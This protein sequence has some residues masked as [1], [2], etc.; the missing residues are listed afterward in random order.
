MKEVVSVFPNRKNYMLT[1]RSWDFI[2]F[3]Q[4]IKR[5]KTVESNIIVGIIDSGIWPESKSFSA[6]GFGSPPTKWKG[7]CRGLTNFTCN[8]KIIGARYYNKNG[9]FSTKDVL[10]PRDTDGHGT[11]MASIIAGNIDNSASFFGLGSGTARGGVPSSR[12]AVYKVCWSSGCDDVDV[13]AAFADAVKDGVDIISISMGDENSR[14]YFMDALSIGSFKAMRHGILT[15]VPAG[16]RGPKPWSVMNVFPW[17]ITVAAS[18]IDRNY[19][20]NLH[21]GNGAV[22]TGVSINMFNQTRVYPMVYG[23]DVPNKRMNASREAAGMCRKNSLDTTLVKGKIVICEE[24]NL[25]VEALS[26]G[27]TGMVIRGPR[28]EDCE[29]YVLPTTYI[30]GNGDIQ[31]RNY[32]MSSSNPTAS[33]LK[34]N[35]G[36]DSSTPYIGSFSSRGPNPISDHILK[37]DL[38]APGVQILAAWT[39]VNAPTR[40]EVDKRRSSYNILF[41]TSI[42][43]AHVAAAAAYVKSFHPSW[44]PAAIRSA[45]MTTTFKMSETATPDAEFA[46]GAGL[47]N[48]ASAINP[49]LVYDTKIVEYVQFLCGQGYTKE[50]LRLVTGDY[51]TSCTDYGSIDS[52]NL[53]IPSFAIRVY[54]SARFNVNMTRKVTNVGSS[55]VY[56]AMISAPPSLKIRVVPETLTFSSVGQTLPFTM[57]V[58][59]IIDGV[60]LVSASLSWIGPRNIVRSPIVVFYKQQP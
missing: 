53:N 24:Y 48:P 22:V 55:F 36:F 39:P 16:N 27:A 20:T 49:G 47:I 40:E 52:L 25:G 51:Y 4:T 26:V 33:I 3:P 46:Y 56:K 6:A 32:F 12:I 35:K 1:T 8:N 9:H 42:A 17:A 30:T 57:F 50:Q 15:L 59:G 41:G 13:I 45:L 37:P 58:E 60:S 19:F 43:C 23:A 29:A 54:P 10:S 21:M 14:N 38:C 11:H 2:K 7:S 44:S 31:A 5:E 34:S 18:T 28:R